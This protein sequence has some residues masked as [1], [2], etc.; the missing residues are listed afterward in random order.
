MKK[1][2][3]TTNTPTVDPDVCCSV[4][5][6][7]IA[8]NSMATEANHLTTL[9]QKQQTLSSVLELADTEYLSTD[10]VVFCKKFAAT[11]NPDSDIASMEEACY[12]IEAAMESLMGNI[13]DIVNKL[14]KK[15]IDFLK[16]ILPF[17]K[18]IAEKIESKLKTLRN[19]KELKWKK[20]D[21]PLLVY[22]EEAYI[23]LPDEIE[24]ICTVTELLN[25]YIYDNVHDVLNGNIKQIP[26]TLLQGKDIKLF[27]RYRIENHINDNYAPITVV[28]EDYPPEHFVDIV[29]NTTQL[30]NAVKIAKKKL[31]RA[32]IITNVH[33]KKASRVLFKY[34]E[35]LSGLYVYITTGTTIL[36]TTYTTLANIEAM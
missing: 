33:T 9:L 27:T 15:I 34:E 30:Y 2:K 21:K 5:E 13:I 20:T 25:N 11:L 17:L 4:S 24:E 12:H 29:Q 35:I 32:R 26:T 8:T 31:K 18:N 16:K 22:R 19:A 28:A 36:R 23:A 1:L 14:I 7:L 6:L 10:T 3:L